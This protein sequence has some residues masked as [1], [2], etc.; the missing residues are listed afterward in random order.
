MQLTVVSD[1]ELPMIPLFFQYLN[2]QGKQD[3]DSVMVRIAGTGLAGAM[4]MDGCGELE[5]S[6]SEVLL[7]QVLRA[8]HLEWSLGLWAGV[9]K[10]QR[11]H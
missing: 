6:P 8:Q 3:F 5:T 10:T 1:T 9:G 4:A 11:M 2:L 7:L